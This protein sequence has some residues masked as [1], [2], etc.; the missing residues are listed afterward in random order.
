MRT[1]PYT[2]Y[3]GH[4]IVKHKTNSNPQVGSGTC[5]ADGSDICSMLFPRLCG[6]IVLMIYPSRR[7]L[8]LTCE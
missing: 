1:W 5:I 4:I 6:L 7:Y 2:V 8:I 3:F